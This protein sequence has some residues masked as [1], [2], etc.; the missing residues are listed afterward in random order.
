MKLIKFWRKPIYDP[1][2]LVRG[3]KIVKVENGYILTASV[4]NLETN[5][6]HWFVEFVKD[7]DKETLLFYKHYAS[8]AFEAA[9]L[10]EVEK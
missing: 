7:Y 1:P 3:E 9:K 8:D 2:F 10:C 4:T 6:V 5:E